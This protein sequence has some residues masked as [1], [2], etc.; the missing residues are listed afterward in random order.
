MIAQDVRVPEA[1]RAQIIIGELQAGKFHQELMDARVNGV[2][3]Q[4][5]ASRK[6]GAINLGGNLMILANYPL[7]SIQD[8]EGEGIAVAPASCSPGSNPFDTTAPTAPDAGPAGTDVQYAA[9]RPVL[10]ESRA[11]SAG[12]TG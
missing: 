6:W 2:M 11:N 9:P 10:D 5:Y 1:V 8:I 12:N 4:V 7:Q 3:V